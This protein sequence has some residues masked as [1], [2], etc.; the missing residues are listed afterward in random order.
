MNSAVHRSSVSSSRRQAFNLGVLYGIGIAVI[1]IVCDLLAAA[2]KLDFFGEINWLIWL[3][4][5][6]LVGYL[7]T[8]RAGKVSIGAL[9]GL[10]A[11][12]GSGIIS[13]AWSIFNVF[14]VGAVALQKSIHQATTK[15]HVT[16]ASTQSIAIVGFALLLIFYLCLEIG[17]GAGLGA[18]GGL[19]TRGRAK[20]HAAILEST[21]SHTVAEADQQ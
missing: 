20:K 13:L 1:G 21:C 8:L 18:L 9:A 3:V 12:L 11:G 19:V 15:S 7:A 16:P 2:T 14:T 5:F 4:G 17:V 10:W 6:L